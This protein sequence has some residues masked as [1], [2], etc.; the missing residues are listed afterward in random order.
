[1]LVHPLPLANF[2]AA[3]LTGCEPQTMA[4]TDSTT[5]GPVQF[6]NWDF[7]DPASGTNNTST[8]QNPTHTFSQAGD[9]TITLH[10]KTALGC[11]DELVKTNYIHVYAIPSVSFTANPQ[12]VNVGGTINFEGSSSVASVASWAWDFGNGTGSGQNVSNPYTI[13]GS[14]PVTLTVT[15]TDGCVKDYTITVEVAPE[16]QFPNV[17]TP[18]GDLNNDA[19]VI[20]GLLPGRVNTFV[21]YNRWG[22]K[23]Y[24]KSS[25]DNT[26]DGEGAADG[27]YYYI[28]TWK[29]PSSSE[30][31]SHS[32]SVTIV[33]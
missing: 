11:E 25:Y 20:K 30:D 26:W 2:K 13:D 4:F 9:Y 1:M 23:I 5:N 12:V 21:V 32:G 31:V 3:P 17:I 27:V 24:E 18:N 8:L 6:Y 29:S 15:T 16:Y 22:K 14:Y 19:F 10:V 7:G 33:R 28:F